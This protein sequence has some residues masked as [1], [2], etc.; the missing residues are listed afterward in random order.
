VSVVSRLRLLVETGASWF[1]GTF[2]T[3]LRTDS[4]PAPLYV[5]LGSGY[6]VPTGWLN[7]DRTINILIARIPGFPVALY[8]LGLLGPEQYERFRQRLWDRARYWDA[9]HRIPIADGAVSAI[10]SS[11]LL[12]H[13][14]RGVAQNLLSDCYRVLK[15]GGVLRVVV[16]DMYLIS[17]S[18]LSIADRLADGQ[19]RP[20]DRVDFLAAKISASDV[21]SAV[22]AEY[23]DADPRRQRL[24]GH[25]WMYDRWSIRTALE[26]AGFQQV[27]ECSYREGLTPDLDQLDYRPAN[28][29]HVEAIKA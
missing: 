19:L 13:L 2:R 5:N 4:L 1:L 27:Q 18:Y 9:R 11:H 6:R 15:S 12:E 8:R 24:F 14:D 20:T 26:R 3:Q 28:S 29:L 17:K 21:S 7:L 22:A 23:Y 25:R 16:P 10:Y